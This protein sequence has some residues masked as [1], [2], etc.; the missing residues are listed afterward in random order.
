VRVSV[1]GVVVE[2]K[3]Y[4]VVEEEAVVEREVSVLEG[5]CLAL[6][7]HGPGQDD[8]MRNSPV[9]ELRACHAQHS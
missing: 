6:V 4:E 9:F 2:L 8:N 5:D 1:F 3:K 7:L